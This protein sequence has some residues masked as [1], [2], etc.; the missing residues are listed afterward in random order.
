VKAY[1]TSFKKFF[2]WMGETGRV[3][4]EVVVDVLTTLKENRDEYL[5][6][7]SE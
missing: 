6:A 7:V 3:S 1:L 4:S 2:Q 5:E